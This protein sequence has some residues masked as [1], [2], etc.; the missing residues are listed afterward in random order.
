[1]E[2]TVKPFNDIIFL[3]WLNIGRQASYVNECEFYR[4]KNAENFR[5]QMEIK[6]FYVFHDLDWLSKL[7]L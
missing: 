1:M 3:V 7:K 6:I 4:S 2:W 5:S